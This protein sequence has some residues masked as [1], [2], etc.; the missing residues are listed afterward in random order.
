MIGHT[1]PET[2][3]PTCTV[4]ENKNIHDSCEPEI[5]PFIDKCLEHLMCSSY[6]ATDA[7]FHLEYNKH[8]SNFV[9]ISVLL[10]HRDKITLLRVALKSRRKFFRQTQSRLNSKHVLPK[11]SIFQNHFLLFT[12][13]YVCNT[14][15]IIKVHPHTEAA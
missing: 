14:T 2:L 8:Q 5:I 9:S 6:T 4:N 13:V 7:C 3:N 11:L 12:F 15:Y 10:L 1:F